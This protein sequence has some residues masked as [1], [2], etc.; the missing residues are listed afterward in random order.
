[1]VKAAAGG[2]IRPR[3]AGMTKVVIREAVPRA[4]V[5]TQMREKDRMRTGI[6]IKTTIS[7]PDFRISQKRVKKAALVKKTKTTP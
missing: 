3:G 7:L 2:A 5:L 1:M 4:V 6:A